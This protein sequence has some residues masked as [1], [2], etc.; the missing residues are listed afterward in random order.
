MTC[1]LLFMA[2]KSSKINNNP[3]SYNCEEE[4]CNWFNKQEGKC[5]LMKSSYKRDYVK[6]TLQCL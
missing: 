3:N 1:P 6:K 5:K 4:K 2:T